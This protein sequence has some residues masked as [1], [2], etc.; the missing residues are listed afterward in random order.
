MI[1]VRNYYIKA[2]T[3]HPIS[4]EAKRVVCPSCFGRENSIAC[5]RCDGWG[6]LFEVV[7]PTQAAFDRLVA[8]WPGSLTYHDG[9]ANF[10][11]ASLGIALIWQMGC[12]VEHAEQIAAAVRQAAEE[13]VRD[14]P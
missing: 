11:E 9:D 7:F 12:E 4:Q 1:P 13:R 5:A 14:E 3:S 2:D 6:Y 8:A 10:S